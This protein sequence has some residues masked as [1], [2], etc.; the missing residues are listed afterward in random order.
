MPSEFI[1]NEQQRQQLQREKDKE[2]FGM[3][4]RSIDS[5]K[6]EKILER[7][8]IGDRRGGAASPASAPASLSNEVECQGQLHV[9]TVFSSFIHSVGIRGSL[10][11]LRELTA[12]PGRANL[13][14]L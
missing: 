6:D 14:H 2:K 12:A 11:I 3:W 13:L 8:G 7:N 1:G 4:S 9:D 5:L 10:C